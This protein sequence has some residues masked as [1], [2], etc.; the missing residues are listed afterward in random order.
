VELCLVYEN[1]QLNISYQKLTKINTKS[2]KC[3]KTK[4]TGKMCNCI[5]WKCAAGQKLKSINDH[6]INIKLRKKNSTENKKGQ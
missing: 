4:E 3:L 1:V 5:L 6:K 2:N